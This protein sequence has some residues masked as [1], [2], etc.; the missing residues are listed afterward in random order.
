MR[1][2]PSLLCAAAALSLA[3]AWMWRAAAQNP[4]AAQGATAIYL[5]RLDAAG[6]WL[7][8]RREADQ[9]PIRFKLTGSSRLVRF[10]TPG[11]LPEEFRPG[12]RL[13]VQSPAPKANSREPVTALEIRDEITEQVRRGQSLVI[14]GQDA[15]TYTFSVRDTRDGKVSKVEYG[16]GTFLVLRED[17]RYVFRVSAGLEVFLN[18]AWPAGAS[19]PIAR[20]VLDGVTRER[21]QKQQALRN[22]ARAEVKGAECDL[23]GK[24]TSVVNLQLRPQYA[25]W[26]ATLKPGDSLQLEGAAA[27]PVTVQVGAVSGEQ[28]RVTGA[29]PGFKPLGTLKLRPASPRHRYAEFIRPMLEVNCLSCHREGNAQSGYSMSNPER[30]F[31][32]SR[33]GVG[34][35]PGKSSESLLY[36]TMSGDRNPRMPTDREPT[37]EQL[38]L[39]RAWID[40]GASV[41]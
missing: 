32:G 15:E 38:A 40:A 34:V 27:T 30:M 10:G 7:E 6:G 35:V 31:M 29:R 5:D 33:R 12:D 24:P 16:R 8:G 20:E 26:A 14:E 41:E 22:L 1:P 21:F 39:L 37:S 11:A 2:R 3:P 18:T 17:P 25:E 13:L 19:Q 9:K 36:L 28:L 23:I 4:T